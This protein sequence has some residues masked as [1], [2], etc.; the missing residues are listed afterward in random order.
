[1]W[2]LACACQHG[3]SARIIEHHGAHLVYI[4]ALVKFL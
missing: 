1:L 2:E 3:H 4:G